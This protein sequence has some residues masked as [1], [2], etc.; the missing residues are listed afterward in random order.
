[1]FTNK[2]FSDFSVKDEVVVGGRYYG[3]K[4]E[5]F[6]AVDSL[7]VECDFRGVNIRQA[8]FGGGR[9]NSTYVECD[10]DGASIWAA[11]PGVAR[12]EGCS[13]RNTIF[14]LLYCMDV[15]FVGCVFSGEIKKGFFNGRTSDDLRSFGGRH[16]NEFHGND[17]SEC[18]LGDISFRSGICLG[19]QK[20][21]KGEQYIYIYEPDKAI[22]I[23][24]R[25][26]D[27]CSRDVASVLLRIIEMDYSSGQGQLFYNKEKFP[28][29]LLPA[30]NE[31]EKFL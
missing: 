22:S 29:K 2:C 19:E 6:S 11:S 7:F 30:I 26:L 14:S 27:C 16:V 28:S 9:E 13:F 5:S 20:L 31:L 4:F 8:C 17:F 10:F 21:P 1:M 15:E 25:G 23:L 24:S 12:F 3:S 18:V